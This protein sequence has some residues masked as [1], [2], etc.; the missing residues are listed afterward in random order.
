MFVLYKLVSV[1]LTHLHCRGQQVR[2]Y[3]VMH[4]HTTGELFTLENMHIHA[5]RPHV[6]QEK[7]N[8]CLKS[9][10]HIFHLHVDTWSYRFSELSTNRRLYRSVFCG[11]LGGIQSWHRLWHQTLS[12]SKVA[13]D[14]RDNVGGFLEHLRPIELEFLPEKREYLPR[15]GCKLGFVCTYA[16]KSILRYLPI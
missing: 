2:S 15:C 3:C 16:L 9:L 8:S 1:I 11:G 5:G 14:K 10:L 12:F 13:S 7:Q 4:P 6:S